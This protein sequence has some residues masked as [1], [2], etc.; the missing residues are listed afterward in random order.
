LHA[1]INQPSGKIAPNESRPPVIN[2]FLP[3]K[4]CCD[5]GLT[6]GIPEVFFSNDKLPVQI[7]Q[8][9]KKRAIFGGN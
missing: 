5:V 3:E 2:A 8:L 9:P 4:S 7:G 1:Q 6:T